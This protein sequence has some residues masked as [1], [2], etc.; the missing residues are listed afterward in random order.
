MDKIRIGVIGCGR[1]GGF[2]ADKVAARS[3]AILAAVCDP[4]E[5]NRTRVAQKQSVAAFAAPDALWD[6]VDAAIVAS[7]S[8][9]HGEIGLNALN[10]GKHLLM[11]KPL[12]ATAEEAKRLTAAADA[13]KLVLAAGHVERFNP[14]WRGAASIFDKMKNSRPLF[15]DAVRTSGYPFRCVDVGVTLDL[16][17]HDLELILSLFDASIEKI[18]AYTSA[19][20]GP[21]EDTAAASLRFADGS[22]V[23]LFAS[24]AEKTA[25][26][27]MTI[28][29][30]SH[31][32]TIDFAART[33]AVTEPDEAILRGDYAPDRVDYPTIQPKVASF[34]AEHYRTTE[35]TFEPFDALAAELDDFLAAI[36][37]EKKLA[38][39]GAR[40]AEAI[41]L[42]ERILA[43]ARLP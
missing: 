15:I 40:A 12:A 17:I 22:F 35:T 19:E 43:E 38:A 6:D 31:R 18:D 2:H 28:R 32:V 42:A 23:R 37:G 5:P 34:M 9:L 21:C 14:A 24:R 11:E 16:M 8:I 36:R 26:R 4:F 3:D 25:K 13:N 33:L 29:S 41:T 27:E 10:A 30:R 1:L 39:P 20:F 7:P